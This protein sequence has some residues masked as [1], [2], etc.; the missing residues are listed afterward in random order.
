MDI[1]GRERDFH[2]R[3][4]RSTVSRCV[5]LDKQMVENRCRRELTVR[6]AKDI[7]EGKRSRI[8]YDR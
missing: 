6:L 2:R 8:L 5:G 1:F 4:S 7:I 3:E